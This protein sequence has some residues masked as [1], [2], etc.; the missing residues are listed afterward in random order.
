[1]EFFLQN[2]IILVVVGSVLLFVLPWLF[3]W[4]Y[5][6]NKR[7]LLANGRSAQA[8]ILEIK[9]SG[10]TIG[11][12]SSRDGGGSMRGVNLLLEVYPEGGQPYQVKTRDQLHLLDLSRIAPGM[13]VTVKVDPNNPQRVAVDFTA[14][15]Q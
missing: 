2:W 10:L 3:V 8:K 14:S 11:T 12:S 15:N 1:M 7:D 5:R 13:M 9:A 4:R 6:A